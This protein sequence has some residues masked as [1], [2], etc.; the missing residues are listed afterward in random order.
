M[1]FTYICSLSVAVSGALFFG[2]S[3]PTQAEGNLI[4]DQ[5]TSVATNLGL[6]GG[7]ATDIATDPTS[8]AVY[9]AAQ[10][11]SGIFS[12]IDLGDTWTGLS[13]STNYG[14]GKGV[15]VDPSTGTVFA[16]IGDSILKSE[17]HGTTWEDITANFGNPIF[18][19][20]MVFGQS[21]LLIA[22]NNGSVG[23]SADGGDTFGEFPVDATMHVTSLASAAAAEVFYAVASDGQSEKLYQS[24]DGGET[25]IDMDVSA[26]GVAAGG[27]FEEITVDPDNDAHVVMISII[28]EFP[29]YQSFDT[30]GTWVE[31]TDE[32]GSPVGGTHATFDGTGR[33]YVGSMYTDDPSAIPTDWEVVSTTTPNSSIYADS[34]ATETED[35]NVLYTNSSYGVARSEDRG[36]TWTDIVNGVTA[37]KVFDVTQADDKNIV[38]LGANGGLAK[39]ENFTDASP[40]WEYPILPTNGISNIR[41]VWVKPDDANVVVMGGS[42]FFFYSTD[43]GVTWAQSVS[44]SFEGGAQDIIQSRVDANTIYAIFFDDDLSDDDTGGVFMSTDAGQTWTDLVLPGNL[45]AISLAVAADDTVYVGIGG[46]S[47]TTGIYQYDGSSWSGLSGSPQTPDI[48][49]LLA[50]PSD[51]NILY[52]TTENDSTGGA[53]YTSDD[54]GVTWTRQDSGIEDLNHLDTL[55][56]Q[57]STGTIYLSGQDGSTLNGVVYKSVDS[58]INWSLV[59]TGLKQESFYTMLFDGLLLGNDRGL[60]GIQSK[61]KLKFS[62]NDSSIQIGDS[63]VLRMT[64]KD[65]ATSNPLDGKKLK[66]F[67][68]V[69]KDGDWVLIETL[70]TNANGKA[71]LELTPAK[72]TRYKVRWVPKKAAAHEYIS[73]TSAIRRLTVD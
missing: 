52:A 44:D 68:K 23:V 10:G 17:D 42:T 45:P 24:L 30:G 13:S 21:R 40:T 58:G 53:F 48:T 1:K 37:V 2:I 9:F 3:T 36:T 65:V 26:H 47:S 34:F 39:T 61:A 4:D 7:Q 8:D 12:S 29:A 46:D 18:Q 19:E 35:F 67:K 32:T 51:P 22:L 14:V 69:G 55:T 6:F 71:R 43:G 11:P 25:W 66:V 54:A 73:V 60:Y 56:L 63:V 5:T 70:I 64:L 41:A 28:G 15:E 72:N 62:L 33:L 31:L 50:D 59:Y 57:D 20:D 38:W 49:S 27:R 16:L